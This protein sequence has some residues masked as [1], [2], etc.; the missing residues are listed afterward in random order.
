MQLANESVAVFQRVLPL[1]NAG[2]ADGG[3]VPT[4][5]T[6]ATMYLDANEQLLQI[7]INSYNLVPIVQ[8]YLNLQR[9]LVMS[10]DANESKVF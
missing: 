7:G 8:M 6:R 2:V 10:F 4:T 5:N 9:Q 3:T 1:A